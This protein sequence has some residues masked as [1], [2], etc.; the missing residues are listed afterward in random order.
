M[1][2]YTSARKLSSAM[3]MYMQMTCIFMNVYFSARKLSSAMSAAKA[4]SD[5]MHDFV[6]GSAG[7]IGMCL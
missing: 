6:C 1:Y 4:I 2:T 7:K 3:S 5:H